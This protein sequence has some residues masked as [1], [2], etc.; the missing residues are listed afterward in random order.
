[1]PERIKNASGPAQHI[2]F[3]LIVDADQISDNIHWQEQGE[4]L[5]CIKMF[6]LNEFVNMGLSR[7]FDLI[8]D[9][10][11]ALWQQR[12]YKNLAHACMGRRILH[13]HVAAHSLSITERDFSVTPLPEQNTSGIL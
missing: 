3:A 11:N 9:F 2:F 12:F 1:M 8:A 5:N 13:D 10:T 4:I 6:T 7:G